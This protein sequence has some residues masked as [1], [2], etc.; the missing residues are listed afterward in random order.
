MLIRSNASLDSALIAAECEWSREFHDMA[1]AQ[2][3]EAKLSN[4]ELAWQKEFVFDRPEVVGIYKRNV[5]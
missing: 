1:V 3:A 4:Q 2:P 5:G